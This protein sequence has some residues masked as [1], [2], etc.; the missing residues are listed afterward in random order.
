M[1]K[2]SLLLLLLASPVQAQGL[3]PVGHRPAAT[4]EQQ[5]VYNPPVAKPVQQPHKSGPPTATLLEAFI[6]SGTVATAEP[7]DAGWVSAEA[8]IVSK[9]KEV[10][11][12]PNA[13][14]E[15]APS[16]DAP[17]YLQFDGKGWTLWIVS[18]RTRFR[19][20]NDGEVAQMARVPVA[21]IRYRI[22][23]K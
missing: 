22:M 12:A 13:V 21:A 3:F 5:V 14:L 11:L 10:W 2:L 4:V 9:R 7:G 19:P 8:V 23:E 6:D 18:P 17:H 20:L 16:K 1:R 15:K